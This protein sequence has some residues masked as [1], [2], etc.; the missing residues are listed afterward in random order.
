MRVDLAPQVVDFV[1]RLAP[2]PRRLLRRALRDLCREQGDIRPLEGPLAGYYRLRARGY[3][4]IFAY[5]GR[6]TIQCVF[7]ERRSIVY[8][9]FAQAL[10]EELAGRAR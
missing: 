8:E 4:I 2:E 10:L 1:R 9:V 6:G 7:A 3:R 5:S